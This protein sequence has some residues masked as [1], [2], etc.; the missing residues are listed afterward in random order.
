MINLTKYAADIVA[1]TLVSAASR[2]VSR[3]F[4][5]QCW[6][7]SERRDESRR[8]RP[9]ACATPAANRRSTM[10][11]GILF[12]VFVIGQSRLPAQNPPPKVDARQMYAKLCAG[13]HGADAH[14]TQ[15]GPGLSGNAR[16]RRTRISRIRNL[17]RTGIPAAGMPPFDLPDDSLDALAALVI[18]LNSSA[19][20]ANVPGDRAAGKNFFFGNGKCDSCHM[21]FGMGQPLGPDLSDT[22]KQMTVDQIRESLLQPDAE[23]TPGYE[24]VTV[25]LKD[26]QTL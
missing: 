19:S 12:G 4:P 22:G 17:I 1:R 18:S 15:Q 5:G 21:V 20:E 24:L 11:I 10:E 14:G 3:L 13:C 26:G 25:H 7:K 8:R 6:F 9:G 23:I 2:L 16:L